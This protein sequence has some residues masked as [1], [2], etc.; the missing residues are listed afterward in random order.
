MSR[1]AVAQ[2]AGYALGRKTDDLITTALDAGAN[3]T[4]I[5]DAASALGKA[6]FITMFETPWRCRHP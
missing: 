5:N 3:S 4:Q 2:S 6:D 1:Q